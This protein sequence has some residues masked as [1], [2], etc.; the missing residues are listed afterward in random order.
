MQPQYDRRKYNIIMTVIVMLIGLYAGIC[1]SLPA[2]PGYSYV[3]WKRDYDTIYRPMM[4][5]NAITHPLW[6]KRYVNEYTVRSVVYVETVLIMVLM[7]CLYF[8]GNY[9]HGKEF[10]TA[11]YA[12]PVRV[13]KM[14]R[15]KNPKDYIYREKV[16]RRWKLF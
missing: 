13:S 16:K 15:C 6:W 11:K 9:I 7:Y 14:L 1:L 4:K 3:E 2:K 12:D 5:K 8:T 10:G